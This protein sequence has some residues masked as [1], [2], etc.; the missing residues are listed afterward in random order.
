MPLLEGSGQATISHNIAEMV[1]AGHPRDQAIAASFRKAGKGNDKALDA[2][3]KHAAG[4]IYV[5]PDG[6]ILLLRRASDE[7][8]YAGH[9][10][11]PG[12]GAEEGESPEMAADRESMEEMGVAPKGTKKLLDQ[13]ITPTGMAF[14]T[15]AQPVKKKFVPTLNKEHSGYAWAPLDQLPE[16][17]HPSVKGL[18]QDEVGFKGDM[19]HSDWDG[20]KKGFM[21]WLQEEEHAQDALAAFAKLR[22]IAADSPIALDWAIK[23]EGV[24]LSVADRQG[25][26]FDR[27]TSRRDTVDG[28]LQVDATPISKAAVNEYRGSEINSVMAGKPGWSDLDP[29]KLYRLYRDPDELAKAAATFNNLPLLSE[30]VPV[31]A[32]AHPSDLVVGATGSDA[33]F[34]H[35]YLRNSL[36]VWKGDD[37]EGVK[38]NKKKELSSAYR[39]RADMKPG[40]TPDGDAYDGVMRDIVGNHVALVTEGRAGSDVLVADS[41]LPHLKELFMTKTVLSRKA[42]MAQ[43]A[44]AV[45]LL[46]KLAKDAKIDLTPILV[47][48]SGKNFKE[49]IP[50]LVTGITDLTKGKLAAGVAL[51]ELPKALDAMADVPMEEG[52]DA[53]PNSGLPMSMAEMKKKTMDADPAAEV[54]TLLQGKVDDATMAKV[55]EMISGG[56]AM[57]ETEEEKAAREKKAMDDEEAKKAMDAEEAK[58]DMVTKPAMDAALKAMEANT[59][60]RA[61]AIQQSIFDARLA[62][63]PYVGDL[64]VAFDSA[65]AVYRSVLISHFAM[66]KADADTLPLAALKSV[67]KSKELPGA[68]KANPAALATDAAQAKSYA[69]RF[70]EAARLSA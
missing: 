12:G 38:S 47:G 30:H 32:E 13:K 36:A 52:A 40:K 15:F 48:I 26:A 55:C 2:V 6:D 50:S 27:D 4:T 66:D 53:D 25:I 57:D 65:E 34:T 46:P 39:Y 21:R 20:L 22:G 3:T 42:A 7:Q 59:L 49:K 60:K 70:P 18:L 45:F 24:R 63:H 37:I 67:L 31:S 33:E 8:N 11:L 54:R 23:L 9:W 16:P 44:L 17:M 29:E 51:D 19:A 5:A 35:P 28:H 58:K 43:G 68:R 1:K 10:S 56:E 14:H 64:K 41:A 62:V 61:T 69:E